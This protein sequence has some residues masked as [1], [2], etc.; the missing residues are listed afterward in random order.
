MRDE[1]SWRPP[2]ESDRGRGMALM[3]A[4][5]GSVEVDRGPGGST[6]TLR[7]TLRL[8]APGSAGDGSAARAS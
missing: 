3:E 5:M 1:G 2:R 7:R 6:V 8:G 4:L